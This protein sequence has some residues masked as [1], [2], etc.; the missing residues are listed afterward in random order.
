MKSQQEH[1]EEYQS[2][3]Y[4]VFENYLDSEKVASLRAVLDPEFSRHHAE[5][6]NRPRAT[7]SSILGHER[8][9][10]PLSEHILN[11]RLLDFAEAVMGPYVQLDSMEISGYP[12]VG[13]EEKGKVAGWHRDAFNL[14]EQWVNYPFTYQRQPRFYTPP[15]ACNWLT[16][17]QNM[18]L[19]SGPLRVVPGSHL[20]YT[21]I[22]EEAHHEPHPNE[23]LVSL[24]AGDMVFTH[25][26]LLHSGTLNTS[27]AIRYFISAYFSHIGLPHRDTFETPTIEQ[28][29]ADARQRNDRRTLRL[30]GINEGF[31]QRQQAAWQQLIDEDK[32]VLTEGIA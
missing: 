2:E 15:M 19:D 5:D 11:P 7:I 14:T 31:Y 25:C 30:F 1:I 4:T 22:T 13:I 21:Y 18:T 16:Y 28:I 8:L 20:D 17:L 26:E 12:S 27:G 29:I 32:S 3:G 10:S 23:K 9:A 6:P 24:Q